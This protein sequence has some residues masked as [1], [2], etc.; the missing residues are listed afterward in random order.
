[1][2]DSESQT[3]F[4]GKFNVFSTTKWLIIAEVGLFF[5]FEVIYLCL[6]TVGSSIIALASSLLVIS[7]VDFYLLAALIIEYYGISKKRKDFVLF[8]CIIRILATLLFAILI[9]L[10]TIQFP[11][12][13]DIK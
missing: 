11:K 7:G 1:M 6:K 10:H 8:G 12:T 5:L 4:C 13:G 3:I 9:V 2:A